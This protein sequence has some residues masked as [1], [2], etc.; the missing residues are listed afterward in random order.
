VVRSAS[1]ISRGSPVTLPP[2]FTPEYY[3]YWREFEAR[4]WWTAGMR[5]VAAMLF[6]M[7]ALPKNG[8]MLDV[9]CGSAQG[10]RWFGGLHPEWTSIGVDP[11][12][13]GLRAATGA[14]FTTVAAASGTALPIRSGSVDVVITLDVMQH[15]PLDGGDRVTLREMHRVLKPGGHLFIRTNVQ[16]FPR[17]SD[18]PVAV[19]HKYDVGELRDKLRDAGFDVL[20]LSRMNALLGLAEI[21]GELRRA[22]ERKQHTSYEVVSKPLRQS[23][24]WSNAIKRAWLRMEGRVVRAGVPLPTGRSLIALCRRG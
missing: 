10:M 8:V 16:A 17:V 24:A 11:G 1:R 23:P 3:A 21:P 7:V 12:L 13:E 2:I 14:G 19:W 15:L 6:E 20:R 18:D 4:H 9:G 5:D 22:R